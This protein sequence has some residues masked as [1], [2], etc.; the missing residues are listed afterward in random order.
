MNTYDTLLSILGDSGKKEWTRSEIIDILSDR[1]RI[2]KVNAANKLDNTQARTDYL[3]QDPVNKR[4]R[5]SRSGTLR[6]EVFENDARSKQRFDLDVDAFIRKYYWAEFLECVDE[7]TEYINIEYDL[8]HKGLP[9]VAERLYDNAKEILPQLNNALKNISKGTPDEHAPKASIVNANNTVLQVEELRTKHLTKFVQIEGRVVFQMPQRSQLT[10][11]AF[12]CMRCGEISYLEQGEPG[13]YYEPFICENDS[14]NRK[15]PFKLLDEPESKYI[16]AQEI[17]IES[18][19]G[20]MDIRLHIT[21]SLCS[22]PW[23][24][25]A[26]VVRV[27]GIVEARQANTKAGKSNYFDWMIEVNSIVFADDSTTE[28]PTEEEITKFEGWVK[29]PFEFKKMFLESIAPH[30][31]GSYVVKDACSLALFS[32]WNW[33]LDPRNVIDRSSIHV[34]LFGD[35]GTG[36]SQIIKDVV[37]IAPKGKF[38]NVT[39]M[40]KGGL[41]TVAVQEKDGWSIKSGFFSLGDQGVLGLDEIDKVDHPDDLKGLNSVLNEQIQL[42][43]KIGK[44]DRPFN[45][46]TA[47]LGA[48]N[49]KRGH[50]VKGDIIDQIAMVFPSHLF[51]RFDLVFVIKDTPDKEMD[52]IV[53]KSIN[54]RYRTGKNDRKG[55][56]RK[57]PV[58]LLRKYIL[59]ARTKPRPDISEGTQKLIE[60]Y[61]G[62]IRALSTEY[63]VIGA[64]QVDDL[65]RLSIAV[66]RRE[67]AKDVTEEHVKY[68]MG[69]MKAALS[70][71]NDEEDYGVY[72]Y[73]KLKSQVE[74]IRLI[75]KAIREICTQKISAPIEEITFVTGLDRMEVE[76]TL[77]QMERNREVFQAGGGYKVNN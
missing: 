56:E 58:E 12:K 3:E 38:G 20:E 35:P 42:V 1:L 74:K 37:Y 65:N 5:F 13:K 51:Q 61:Y 57:I 68:A 6:Y 66:A 16:D 31:Y 77:M 49:P 39:N 75:L 64:R 76:H 48:A 52:R 22:P 32:D 44:N 29:N 43:S 50:L 62:K 71:L 55:L 15:G 59:Y 2:D 14:C 7:H 18:L 10:R 47:V 33:S 19:K 46:R 41:S 27:C 9:R 30:I 17:V 67:M 11:G 53:A 25:D 21:E 69:L 8:L 60:E 63:P 26:K 72:N 4:Y 45:T 70:T 23:M 54:E 36:K 24:R 34:L 40:S 28:P 73:G